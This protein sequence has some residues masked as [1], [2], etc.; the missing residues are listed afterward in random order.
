[1]GSEDSFT[2][3]ISLGALRC[4]GNPEHK[5]PIGSPRC[6]LHVAIQDT[7]KE[8]YDD[9]VL[10]DDSG[11]DMWKPRWATHWQVQGTFHSK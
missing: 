5:G 2:S 11:V 8:D 4:D 10:A 9:V 1:L 7:R 3:E 6:M